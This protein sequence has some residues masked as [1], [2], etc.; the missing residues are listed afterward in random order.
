MQDWTSLRDAY[1]EASKVPKLLSQLST[2]PGH[3]VWHEVWSRLC[4]QGTVYS[5][6]FAALPLLLE[7]AETVPPE[8]R[9]TVLVLAGA[10]T[11]SRDVVSGSE[12][13]PVALAATSKRFEAL[14]VE[15]L[16]EPRLSSSDFIHV[17]QAALAFRQEPVWGEVLDQFNDGEFKGLCGSCGSDLYLVVG[18]HGFFA[19]NYDWASPLTKRAPISASPVQSLGDVGR[20]LYGQAV[21][22]KQVQIANWTL[23]LFGT[24]ECPACGKSIRVADAVKQAYD[25]LIEC[26]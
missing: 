26:G 4:H 10:I 24:T 14:A 17:A 9:S 11:S 12:A 5:A 25:R 3:A 7:W 16:A 20:W 18:Q 13:R 2:D 23:H 15:T 6:S 19:T 21:G 8:K 22:G 1:G